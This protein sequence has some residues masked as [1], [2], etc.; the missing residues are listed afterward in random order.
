MMRRAMTDT[1][2][3]DALVEATDKNKD[4]EVAGEE[5][6]AFFKDRD[7]GDLVWNLDRGRRGGRDARRGSGSES[8]SGAPAGETAPD[9]TLYPPEGGDPVTLSAFSG[10][11]PVA[12][13]FGSYT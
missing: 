3:W 13:I 1:D 9:F 6:V 4:G 11:V 10:N 7:D 12:L 5:I 2:P 8:M